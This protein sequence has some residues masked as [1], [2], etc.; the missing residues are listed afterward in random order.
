MSSSNDQGSAPT[1]T[2]MRITISD[3]TSPKY[4]RAYIGSN[5]NPYRAYIIL[6]G[7]AVVTAILGQALLGSTILGNGSE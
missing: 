1:N 6:G 4:Y 3:G 7:G 2:R 5:S